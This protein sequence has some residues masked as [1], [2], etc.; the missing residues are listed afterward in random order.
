MRQNAAERK[1]MGAQVPMISEKINIVLGENS[2]QKEKEKGKRP[3]PIRKK[4]HTHVPNS[5]KL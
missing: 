5:S 4:K 3:P 2:L 1:D